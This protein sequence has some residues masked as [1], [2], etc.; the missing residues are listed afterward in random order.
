MTEILY[1]TGGFAF[2]L[3]EFWGT[4][5]T[6][7]IV[8]IGLALASETALATWLV[9]SQPEVE[10]VGIKMQIFQ[11]LWLTPLLFCSNTCAIEAYKT[12]WDPKDFVTDAVPPEGY[13]REISNFCLVFYA[14]THSE[15]DWHSDVG[16]WD[17]ASRLAIMIIVVVPMHVVTGLFFWGVYFTHILHP[18][19]EYQAL[20][21][22][23]G[24]CACCKKDENE[25][26]GLAV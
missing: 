6:T 23:E 18:L 11:V 8:I 12:Y 17:H 21:P 13:W 4:N 15:H 14:M 1:R 25:V 19:G 22:F 24:C 5:R 10:D 16:G 26:I 9:V 3:W 20:E 7:C 2:F